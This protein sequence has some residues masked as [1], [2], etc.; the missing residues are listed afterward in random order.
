MRVKR[1]R[2]IADG[3]KK[4]EITT[5]PQEVDAIVERVWEAIYD[6]MVG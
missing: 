2:D 3:G 4:G 5:N 1:D 6:G